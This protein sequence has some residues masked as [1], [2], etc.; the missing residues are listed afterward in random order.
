MFLNKELKMYIENNVFPQY[1]KNEN[2]HKIDHINYVINRCFELG[3][4]KNIDFNML[5]TIAAVG[6][7]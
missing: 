7:G 6:C 3:E 1:A 2:G 4:D 5:Y